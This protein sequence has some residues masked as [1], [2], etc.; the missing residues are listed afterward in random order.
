MQALDELLSL[1]RDM[2]DAQKQE[3]IESAKKLL[4]QQQKNATE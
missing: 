2:T 4:E 3:L 1:F